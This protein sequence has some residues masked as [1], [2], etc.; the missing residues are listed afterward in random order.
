MIILCKTTL[1]SEVTLHNGDERKYIVCIGFFSYV[2]VSYT[3]LDVYKR[4]GYNSF[5]KLFRPLLTITKID[6]SNNMVLHTCTKDV[7][8][9]QLQ[10]SLQR[11]F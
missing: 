8:K 11:S 4:Q 7:Y 6:Y 5:H 2:P 1:H 10:F 9:R 3:H